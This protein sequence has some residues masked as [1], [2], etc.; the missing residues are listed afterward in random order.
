MG[1]QVSGGQRSE[2][3]KSKRLG[4][5]E[6]LGAAPS[7]SFGLAAAIA[8]FHVKPT[9]DKSFIE[10]KSCGPAQTIMTTVVSYRFWPPMILEERY[11]R[12]HTIAGALL[13]CL[14]CFE[15]FVSS[16]VSAQDSCRRGRKLRVTVSL[17]R[18]GRRLKGPSAAAPLWL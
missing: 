10:T 18:D 3:E 2:V 12:S 4:G 1:R 13:L 7:E 8:L 5:P 11:L 14:L 17:G 15:G 6:T 16:G 9:R